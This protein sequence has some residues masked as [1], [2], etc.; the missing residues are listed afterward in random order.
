MKDIWKS[1]AI[2]EL[3][4]YPAKKTSLET[5]PERIRELEMEYISIGSPSVDK[6]SVKSSKENDKALNNIA[7]REALA[8]NYSEANRFVSRVER[9]LSALSD[10]EVE[11][12]SRCYMRPELRAVERIAQTLGV[13]KNTV[14]RKRDDAL[15]KFTIA[16]FG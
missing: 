14:Y 5:I 16:M 9:G 11:L 13:E 6:I 12:I 3:T 8:R 10:D 4:I 7:Q 15:R 1:M 2:D